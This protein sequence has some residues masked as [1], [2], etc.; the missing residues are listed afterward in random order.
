MPVARFVL[1]ALSAAAFAL[2]GYALFVEPPALWFASVCF[3]AYA[4]YCT[5]GVIVPKLQLYGDVVCRLPSPKHIA[6]TFDDGPHPETTREVLRLLEQSHQRATFFI[7]G[8][9]AAK[10]PDLVREIAKA[11]HGLGLHGFAHDWLYS[12]RSPAFVVRDVR[13][14]QEAIERACGQRPKLLRP[15][16]GYISH[17]TVA[18]AARAGVVLIGW[19]VRSL[20]G[21]RGADGKRVEK[22]IARGLVPGAI[23]LLHDASEQEDFVPASVSALWSILQELERRGLRSDRL[24][25]QG[26]KADSSTTKRA[27]SV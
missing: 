8:R 9:K 25:L 6:L 1:W 21:F 10:Y 26:F 13:K 24:A 12:L 16:I 2:L 5:L 11:G 22:R 20:D 7:V 4:A 23:V 3:V 19:S 27:P 17:R 15:P 18:G 14:T